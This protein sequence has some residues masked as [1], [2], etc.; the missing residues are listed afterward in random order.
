[1]EEIIP[2]ELSPGLHQEIER[3]VTQSVTRRKRMVGCRAEAL[4]W[5]GGWGGFRGP[6][7][8]CCWSKCLTKPL[9]LAHSRKALENST[10]RLCHS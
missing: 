1:M 7:S 2:S 9:E 6:L 5:P 4:T 10:A 3:S 8:S